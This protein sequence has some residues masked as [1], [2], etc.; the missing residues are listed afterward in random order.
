MTTIAAALAA[1]GTVVMGADTYSW[2]HNT[3]TPG[4]VKVWAHPVADGQRSVLVAA[5]GQAAVK[6]LVRAHWKLGGVPGDADTDDQADTW[7][8]ACA[9]AVAGIAADARPPATGEDGYVDAVL[10]LACGGRLWKLC[11]QAAVP[12]Y[13]AADFYAAGS[14]GDV[15]LGALHVLHEH[16]DRSLPVVTD[17]VDRA[18]RTAC[19]WDAWSR[20]DR[21]GPTILRLDRAG[22]LS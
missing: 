3:A 21:A 22:R 4:A 10:L 20:V 8:A 15:A 6:D 16:P 11:Q 17:R 14:G 13:R 5:S 7:A 1:D 9:E 18:L 12:L 19:A 2:Y